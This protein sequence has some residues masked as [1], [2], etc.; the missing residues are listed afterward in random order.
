MSLVTFVLGAAVGAGGAWYYLNQKSSDEV[1]ERDREINR[2]KNELAT[3]QRSPEPSPPAQLSSPNQAKKAQ[4]KV[5]TSSRKDDLTRI[6]GIGKVLAEKLNEIGIE[7]F[8]QIANF[9]QADI[10]HVKQ[11]INIRGR[12]EPK[13]WVDQARSLIKQDQSKS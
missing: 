8:E 3:A 1:A 7:S 2:L 13:N 12:G 9:K 5:K 11:E 4:P 6:K 10:D